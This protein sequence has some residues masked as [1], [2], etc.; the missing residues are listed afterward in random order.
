MA[1]AKGFPA[2]QASVCELHGKAGRGTARASKRV[3]GGEHAASL[4]LEL[5]GALRTDVSSGSVPRGGGKA[6]LS[7]G[8]G[9]ALGGE[10][11]VA[12]MA[13]MASFNR[14]SGEG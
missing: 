11:V 2:N 7:A 3:G 6:P 4:P 5:A 1:R 14:K 13:N 8:V 10:G 9:K 12:V